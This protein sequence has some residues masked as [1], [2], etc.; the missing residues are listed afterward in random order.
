MTEEFKQYTIKREVTPMEREIKTLQNL[1]ETFIVSLDLRKG[2]QIEI[3]EEY[4]IVQGNNCIGVLK[5]GDFIASILEDKPFLRREAYTW[6]IDNMDLI[7]EK[8]KVEQDKNERFIHSLLDK[9]E[10][11]II[12]QKASL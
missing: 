4:V 1:L 3:D 11:R 10:E 12:K 5:N 2:E 9:L 6:F 8:V 7:A